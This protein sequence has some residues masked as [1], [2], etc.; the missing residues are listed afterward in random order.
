MIGN[1]NSQTIVRRSIEVSMTAP[2]IPASISDVAR[3]WCLSLPSPKTANVSS[4]ISSN[5]AAAKLSRMISSKA[6][7]SI[8]ALAARNLSA[9]ESLGSCFRYLKI[10]LNH[11][12]SISFPIVTRLLHSSS[13]YS[14]SFLTLDL[15]AGMVLP[16]TSQPGYS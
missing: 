11:C 16:Q 10:V 12:R 4:L 3:C 7:V 8:I 5:V 15:Y 1:A 6:K 13:S 9:L 2:I 14:M